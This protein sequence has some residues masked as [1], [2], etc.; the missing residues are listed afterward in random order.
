MKIVT[1][2]MQF[3]LLFILAELCVAEETKCYFISVR[4]AKIMEEGRVLE[5][6]ADWPCEQ[7]LSEKVK[8]IFLKAQHVPVWAR[9]TDD[10]KL[11]L[12]IEIDAGSCGV[13][14]HDTRKV[15]FDLGELRKSRVNFPTAPGAIKPL[16]RDD[17]ETALKE[18]KLEPCTTVPALVQTGYCASPRINGYCKKE[19]STTFCD[20]CF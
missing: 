4:G 17:Y 15:K 13:A 18:H 20:P 6:F 11:C 9:D 1:T 16:L 12:G 10:G 5:V 19:D 8:G 14:P 2:T 7:D 3:I